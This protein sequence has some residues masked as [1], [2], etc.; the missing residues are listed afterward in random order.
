LLLPNVNESFKQAIASKY[1]QKL[2]FF[3]RN[4]TYQ[5]KNAKDGEILNEGKAKAFFKQFYH[6]GDELQFGNSKIKGCQWIL[7]RNL[8][9]RSNLVAEEINERIN[10]HM[11]EKVKLKL[12]IPQPSYAFIAWKK[13]PKY[14]GW[15]GVM[16]EEVDN[17][18]PPG[19]FLA[20][21]LPL[22]AQ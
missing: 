16:V 10:A 9:A 20:A 21:Y 2:Y 4:N 7:D 3:A 12:Q 6:H 1:S 18:T 22:N 11:L 19:R 15:E 8:Q 5:I 17:L 13:R 14:V